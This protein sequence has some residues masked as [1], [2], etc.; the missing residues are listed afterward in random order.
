MIIY[1]KRRKTFRKNRYFSYTS[2]VGSDNTLPT[3]I[4]T[5]HRV[6]R[7][8]EIKIKKV[9]VLYSYFLKVYCLADWESDNTPLT[10]K[11]N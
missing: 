1:K 9:F 2:V 3:K 6:V 8:A 4:R 7:R 10:R 5:E 11:E